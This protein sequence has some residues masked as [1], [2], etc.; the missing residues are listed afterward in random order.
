MLDPSS[1]KNSLLILLTLLTF[2]ARAAAKQTTLSLSATCAL[3][4]A[5]KQFTVG[6]WARTPICDDECL[7]H[8][9]LLTDLLRPY[10]QMKILPELLT[11]RELEGLDALLIPGGYMDEARELLTREEKLAMEKF[12]QSGG[13]YMGTC[14][15]GYLAAQTIQG[16]CLAPGVQARHYTGRSWEKVRLSGA[17]EQWVEDSV[18]NRALRLGA[19]PTTTLKYVNGPVLEVSSPSVEV[20]GTFIGSRELKGKTASVRLRNGKGRV[21][22]ISPHPELSPA[23][24]TLFLNA[25]VHELLARD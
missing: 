25:L 6:L 10:V 12:V 13:L 14:M 8:T 21:F 11:S 18:W 20:T 1:L 7:M 15:G 16:V 5:G 22:L 17:A 3:Q 24:Q 9:S 2:S 4:T 23:G 19:G